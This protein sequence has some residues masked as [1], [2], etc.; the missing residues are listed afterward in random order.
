MYLV[1]SSNKVFCTNLELMNILTK[2]LKDFVKHFQLFCTIKIVRI[3]D[4]Q[5]YQIMLQ[6]IQ[7]H[8]IL[9]IQATQNFTPLNLYF[10]K[11]LLIKTTISS[12]C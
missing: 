12:C 3:S 2:H 9:S 10:L 6:T 7:I 4:F 5:K 11:A 8:S 1:F